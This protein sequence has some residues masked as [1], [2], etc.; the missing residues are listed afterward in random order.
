[1]LPRIVY[2]ATC[3]VC[4][5]FMRMIRYK[6]KNGAEYFPADKDAT[7]FK[8]IDANGKSYLGDAAIDKMTEDFPAIKEY[9]FMLPEKYRVKGLKAVYKVASPVRKVIGAVKKGCNCGKH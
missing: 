5:N 7:D 9:M 2:D 4:T 3:P 6:V 1:M 8:Y